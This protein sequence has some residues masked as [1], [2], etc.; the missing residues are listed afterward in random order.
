[1]ENPKMYGGKSFDEMVDESLST[2]PDYEVT[3][4]LSPEESDE[5]GEYLNDPGHSASG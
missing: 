2:V 3:G 5:V 1:M 4:V